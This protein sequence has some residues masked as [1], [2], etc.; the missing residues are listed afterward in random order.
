MACSLFIDAEKTENRQKAQ[1]CPVADGRQKDAE[2]PVRSQ[3]TAENGHRGARA[4]LLGRPGS[5]AGAAAVRPG[6]DRLPPVLVLRGYNRGRGALY[7]VGGI[8]N[9]LAAFD[10][11]RARFGPCATSASGGANAGRRSA[12]GPGPPA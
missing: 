8:F 12:A 1:K 9:S 4:P 10:G 11:G 6:P 2:K 3:K 7:Y 5:A